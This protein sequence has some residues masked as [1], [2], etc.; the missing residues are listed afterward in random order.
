ML[1][2][3]SATFEREITKG[4]IIID[5]WAPWCG[6]CK[7]IG[8]IFEKISSDYAGKLAFAKLN[9]DDNGA[10]AQ[11]KSVLGIPCLI[12]FNNGEEIER[13]VGS[14]PEASLRKKIDAALAKVA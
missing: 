4:P 7:T 10:L 2:L 11:E 9:V 3:D 5:F 14:F 13:I 6:P 8:P 12:M 1:E